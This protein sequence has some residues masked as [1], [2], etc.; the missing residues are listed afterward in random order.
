MTATE[1]ISEKHSHFGEQAQLPFRYLSVMFLLGQSI[2][3]FIASFTDESTD[4]LAH[5]DV[6]LSIWQNIWA[7]PHSHHPYSQTRDGSTVTGTGRPG[8]IEGWRW[9]QKKSNPEWKPFPECS[10]SPAWA[11]VSIR[12]CSKAHRQ[13]N[14]RVSFGKLCE[15]PGVVQP[16]PG[17][18]PNR[19]S[20]ERPF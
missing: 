3:H 8:R 12:Q 11:K 6:W 14:T 19:A 10:G 16:E 17:P 7:L 13:E 1:G 18:E 5:V 20:L 15:S 2:W 9:V 4:H